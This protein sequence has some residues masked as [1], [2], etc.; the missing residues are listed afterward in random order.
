MLGLPGLLKTAS[1]R[2]VLGGPS[3]LGPPCW[4][5]LAPLPPALPELPL[6]AGQGY[7]P[8]LLLMLLVMGALA[9]L[10]G[11]GDWRREEF[12]LRLGFNPGTGWDVRRWL[13]PLLAVEAGILW[14][15]VPAGKPALN[16]QLLQVTVGI[17]EELT[18][19]GVLLVLLDRV[20]EGRVRVLGAEVRLG[21]LANSLVFEACPGLRGGPEDYR[22]LSLLSMVILTAGGFVLAWCRARNGSV[23][24][25]IFVYSGMKEAVQLVA[26]VKVWP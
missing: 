25:L 17:T 24:L 2:Y 14:A 12:G 7:W 16:Y 6:I 11:S 23:L 9:L 19:R 5:G 10:L 26:L 21:T 18:F 4:P 13:L 20:F 8:N 15:L 22:G 1:R 3:S